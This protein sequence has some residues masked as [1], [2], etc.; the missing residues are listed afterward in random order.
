MKIKA[1]AKINLCLK[2][3]KKDN[4]SKH[5]IDSVLLLY[6]KLFDTIKIKKN[7]TF[8]ISYFYR[9][10]KIEVENCLVTKTINY[11]KEK[12]QLDC[13]YKI[14]IKKKIPFG[15]GLG[16][17]SSDAASIINFLIEGKEINLDLRD[18]ALKLGSDIPFFLSGYKI[19]RARN[20]GELVSPIY[21]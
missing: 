11:L 9:K 17:G 15:S 19:A 2:V 12:F 10:Q 20:Y 1:Y 4:E 13:N 6:K 3:F 8:S 7:K 14:I 18:I 5:Q 16:G 21:N